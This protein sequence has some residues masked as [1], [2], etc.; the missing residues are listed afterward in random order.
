MNDG[1]DRT[2]DKN[3]SGIIRPNSNDLENQEF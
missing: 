1:N 3:K 2:V